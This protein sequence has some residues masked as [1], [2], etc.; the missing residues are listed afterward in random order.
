M[1]NIVASLV[2]VG[3]VLI[4]LILSHYQKIKFKLTRSFNHIVHFKKWRNFIYFFFTFSKIAISFTI[5]KSSLIKS[6]IH[7]VIMR[8]LVQY[9]PFIFHLL[10]QNFFQGFEKKKI[11]VIHNL[12]LIHYFENLQWYIYWFYTLWYSWT[13]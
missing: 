9:S 10:L 4:S 2:L 6:L 13:N 5:P 8:S 7:I 3:L 11:W 1:N 12:W